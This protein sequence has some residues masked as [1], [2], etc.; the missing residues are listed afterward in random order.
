[1]YTVKNKIP[2]VSSL[3][4]KTNYDTKISETEK[5]LTDHNHDKYIATPEFNKF[6]VETFAARLAQAN[7]V[8][9]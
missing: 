7:F 6:T 9:N 5:E 4:K 3:V 2:D 1:M 8:T